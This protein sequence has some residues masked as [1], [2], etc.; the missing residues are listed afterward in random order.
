[1][2][3]VGSLCTYSPAPPADC[4]LLPCAR[5]YQYLG[6]WFDAALRADPHVAHMRSKAQ[7]ASNLLRAIQRPNQPPGFAVIRTL[8]QVMLVPRLTYG[9]PF[10]R[11]S[12]AQFA[13]LNA[14]MFRPLQSVL[15]LPASVH[16]ASLAAWTGVPVVE[17]LRE[18]ALLG[19][20]ASVLRSTRDCE[21]RVH[22]GRFPAIELVASR[23]TRA[24]VKATLAR[25]R[26]ARRA[27]K[28]LA[29]VVD[30]HSP[31]DEFALLAQRWGVVALLPTQRT[32]T[33]LE[34]DGWSGG[35]RFSK[36]VKRGVH[37]FQ[38][39]RMLLQARGHDVAVTGKPETDG[40]VRR[41]V[42]APRGALLP[43]LLG[44]ADAAA[45][46]RSLMAQAD[47][48]TRAK[49]WP[50]GPA[51][52]LLADSRTVACLRSRLALNRAA[53]NG[54]RTGGQLRTRAD[55]AQH[56]RCEQ[57]AVWP[58]AEETA[59]HTI[60][61]C[62]QYFIPRAKLMRRIHT[63]VHALREHLAQQAATAQVQADADQLFTMVVLGTPQLNAI[64]SVDA[65]ERLR[66][67]TGGFL[68]SVSRVRPF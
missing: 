44:V 26:K 19:V 39:G 42:E 64:L 49:R 9:L 67:L 35:A 31:F 14:I 15:R 7:E 34:G 28:R 55:G 33:E 60:A 56:P 68:L 27:G 10:V 57:C 40:A 6:V 21:V 18:Q 43:P 48:M 32:V 61:R 17:L 2:V 47:A 52:T 8:V 12:K 37:A 50:P 3:N 53:L 46:P 20:V 4:V 16:R 51:P 36:H 29:S 1:V 13:K 25:A 65:R 30:A 11:P 41:D 59:E 24:A 23:C 45:K 63:V 58:A 54:V 22:L 38:R 5:K 62:S 66:R